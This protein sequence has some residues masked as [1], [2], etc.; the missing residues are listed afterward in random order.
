MRIWSEQKGRSMIEMLGVLA[1]IG[2]LSTGGIAGYTKAMAS[3]RA[4]KLADQ[5]QLVVSNYITFTETS[6]N[7]N[8]M[9]NE[10]VINH[11]LLPPEMI[12]EKGECVHALHGR[13]QISRNSDGSDDFV[14]RF[15]D[16]DRDICVYLLTLPYNGY[17]KLMTVNKVGENTVLSSGWGTRFTGV[18]TTSEAAKYCVD[19]QNAVRWHF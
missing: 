12:N 5:V 7:R 15:G 6:N 19:E 4:K 9:F 3:Y 13:C 14:V 11:V 2:V 10:K 18:V 17:T 1:I 8:E 16:L